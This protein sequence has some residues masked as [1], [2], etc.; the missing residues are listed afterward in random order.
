MK[1]VR[2][3]KAFEFYPITTMAWTEVPTGVYQVKEDEGFIAPK[4]FYYLFRGDQTYG[5]IQDFEWEEF[6]D[7][8]AIRCLE[9]LT[10]NVIHL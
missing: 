6:V 8:G 2:I 7:D 1:Q 10:G 9:K 5:P 3:T 4:K